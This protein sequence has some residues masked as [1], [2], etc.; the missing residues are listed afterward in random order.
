VSP[1]HR[2]G[3]KA[4]VAHG[5]GRKALVEMARRHLEHLK[6]G[7]VD[8]APSVHRVPARHYTDPERAR[9]E[10]ERIF[11]RLPLVL[12]LSCELRE[13]GAYKATWAIGVPVLI[14]RGADGGLRA[15]RN[16]CSHR[17]AVVVPEGLGCARRFSCPYHGWTYDADGALVGISDRSEFGE[18]DAGRLGL[19]PLPVAERAGLVFV[20]LR[21]DAPLDVDSF[22]CGY[23]EVLAQLGLE[24][25]H[26]VGRQSVAGPGWKIA[27]D[28]Y[29]DFYHLPIL[30][31]NSFG[32]RV[33]NRA[34]YDAWGPHQR[35]SM[36]N[37]MLERVESLPEDEWDAEAL[38]GG[39]WTVFPHL[40]IADFPVAG[41]LY[42]VSQL[43]PGARADESVT[44][45]SFL[46]TRDPGEEERAAITQ[47][48][49]FLEHVVRDEDYATGLGIQHALESGALR[50][51]LFGRNELGGQRFHRFVDAVLESDDAALPAL[52][53]AG[54]GRRGDP[55]EERA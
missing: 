20:T 18:V 35:V 53:A 39:V 22:L 28:G 5:E 25:C 40:S 52:F 27:Y 6:A 1:S 21:P 8:R 46:A 10:R 3:R 16:V 12:G 51:V 29:L 14:V 34:L 49:H 47:A 50:E 44:V 55:R 37:P 13:P 31:R 33:P 4:L 23:D 26:L 15:F 11:R 41:R 9:I 54:P 17:G 24:R 32:P 38:V 36:P 43:L 48:M 2:E 42:L 19:A 30:H 7:T 45:Q